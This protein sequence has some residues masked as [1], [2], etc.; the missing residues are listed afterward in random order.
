MTK[1]S[2]KIKNI[3]YWYIFVAKILFSCTTPHEPFNTM[4]SL[5]KTNEPI[6]GKLSGERIERP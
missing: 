1:T 6:L 5:K 2:N 4:L 3:Y